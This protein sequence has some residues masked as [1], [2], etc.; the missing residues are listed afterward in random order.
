MNVREATLSFVSNS[1]LALKLHS[2]PYAV[3]LEKGIERNS[4]R[5][6]DPNIFFKI[7]YSK[8]YSKMKKI[9]LSSATSKFVLLF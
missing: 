3:V 5:P 6:E 4:F 7:F 2:L 8:Y 9:I 1:V